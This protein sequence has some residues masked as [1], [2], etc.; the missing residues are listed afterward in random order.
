MELVDKKVADRLELVRK[1]FG[2]SNNKMAEVIGHKLKGDTLR[3]SIER[4]RVQKIYV[5]SAIHKL[6]ISRAWIFDGIGDMKADNSAVEEKIYFE[7]DNVRAS[8][9][10]ILD[11]LDEYEQSLSDKDNDYKAWLDNKVNAKMFQVFREN[12]VNF[13]VVV[14]NPIDKQ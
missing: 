12:K 9:K 10:E 1:E 11:F 7:K 5:L 6:G 13:N 2:Y 3:K 14:N 8:I 4:G